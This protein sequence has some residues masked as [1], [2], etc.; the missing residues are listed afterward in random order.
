[1]RETGQT[2]DVKSGE[3]LERIDVRLPRGA[4]LAGHITDEFGV[5]Y[6]G[7]RVEAMDLRYI[8]GSR[9]R[10]PFP[11]ALA[12]TDD[13]GAFR[14]SGLQPGSYYLKASSTE[15][16][17]GPDRRSYGYAATFFPGVPIDQAQPISLGLA[18][19]RTGLALSLP[20]GRPVRVSGLVQGADGTPLAGE[21][22][23]MP[24]AQFLGPETAMFT[25]GVASVRTTGQGTFEIRDVMPGDYRL[26]TSRR[27]SDGQ[28]ETVSMR[29]RVGDS[30]VEGL[31]LQ[32]RVGSTITGQVV[33]DDG[34]PLAFP[35]GRLRVQIFPGDEE[36]EISSMRSFE[37]AAGGSLRMTPMR[38]PVLFRLT[39]LP[40]T[41]MIKSIRLND[42]D[43]TEVPFDIPTGG[44]EIEGLRIVIS[45]KMGSVSGSVT[46]EKGTTTSDATVV[47]FA[48]DARLWLPYTRFVRT[49][50]PGADGRFTIR[51]LPPGKYLATART[52]VEDAQENDPVFLESLRRDA[53]ALELLEGGSATLTL[54]LPRP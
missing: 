38:G 45:Q 35:A 18:Q 53:S 13:R 32:P 6:P 11:A 5:P 10:V 12:I 44:K 24:S 15:K 51:Q 27:S 34:T 46:D 14:M 29:L 3:T 47:L 54:K 40:D 42:D 23:T 52:L 49:M 19:Q 39:G 26:S 1:V 4:V 21:T 30:P 20:I 43:I 37:V 36:K 9:R 41:W 7:V 28:T 31:L 22:V 33:T 8:A 50:R 2:I 16:W 25:I 17:T 48:E